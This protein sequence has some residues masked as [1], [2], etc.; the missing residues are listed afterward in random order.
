MYSLLKTVEIFR[1]LFV[2]RLV[3]YILNLTIVIWLLNDIKSIN[4]SQQ[5]DIHPF[6]SDTSV[7]TDEF[8]D[9]NMYDYHNQILI[10][11]VPVDSIVTF[12]RYIRIANT[13]FTERSFSNFCNRYDGRISYK[14]LSLPLT[15]FMLDEERKYL[16]DVEI[17]IKILLYQMTKLETLILLKESDDTYEEDRVQGI[18][19]CRRLLDFSLALIKQLRYAAEQQHIRQ[20]T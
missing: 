7:D 17:T 19:L 13:A 2:G 18:A 20:L 11:N 8:T 3:S 10:V 15:V 6:D 4:W 1:N 12:I 9:F 5:P 14:R 16:K